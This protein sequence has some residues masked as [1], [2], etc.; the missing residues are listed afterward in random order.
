MAG[1]DKS[2]FLFCAGCSVEPVVSGNGG[3]AVA[4]AVVQ[5]R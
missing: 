2:L 5:K 4:A 1:T 3:C